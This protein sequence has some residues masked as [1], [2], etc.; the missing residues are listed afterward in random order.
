MFGSLGKKRF[1]SL[2]TVGGSLSQLS[3]SIF[4]FLSPPFF[5]SCH[6]CLL[7]KRGSREAGSPNHAGIKSEPGSEADPDPAQRLP[8][9]IST[10]EYNFAQPSDLWGL[11]PDREAIMPH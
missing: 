2:A 10:N 4:L 9:Q 5:L 8:S 11:I 1:E 7:L 3:F 6:S